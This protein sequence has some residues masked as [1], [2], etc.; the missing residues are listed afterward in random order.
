MKRFL[1]YNKHLKQQARD[2]RKNMTKAEIKLWKEFL[3]AFSY[4]CYRQK[5]IDN[6]IVDFYCPKLKLVIELDG[7][8]HFTDEGIAYD[9]ERTN[10]LNGYGL[11]VLRFSNDVVMNNFEYVKQ[12]ISNFE[13]QNHPNFE[14]QNHPN[15]L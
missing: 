11:F 6:F 3:V 15:P 7:A 5:I 13:T 9:E 12:K 10:I 8:K 1:D 14:T 4:K 2:L